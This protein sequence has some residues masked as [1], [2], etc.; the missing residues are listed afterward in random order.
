MKKIRKRKHSESK[1]V[2]FAHVTQKIK[3]K[4]YSGVKVEQKKLKIL[5]V[6]A[7]SCFIYDKRAD[8]LVIV[9]HEFFAVKLIY[10]F[11]DFAFF[12]KHLVFNFMFK[13]C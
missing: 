8:S 1:Y 12:G 4:Y 3:S 2:I 7:V 10:E 13:K 5:F 6:R 11:A 9:L